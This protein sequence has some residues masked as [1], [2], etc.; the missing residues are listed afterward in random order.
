M[1]S[2]ANQIERHIQETRDDLSGN[3][4]ELEEK[5]KSAVDWRVQF[6]DRPMTLLALAFGGGVLV[7]ALLPSDRPSSK[8][9]SG[10]EAPETATSSHAMQVFS[11]SNGKASH[12]LKVWDAFK[13]A[14]I[15][16]ATAKLTGVIEELVPGFETEFTKAQ[17]SNGSGRSA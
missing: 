8:R 14:L 2:T 16:V 17:G 12:T 7:S 13:G 15:G 6:K 1:D 5:V 9:Y 4:R 3:F 11:P 10:S